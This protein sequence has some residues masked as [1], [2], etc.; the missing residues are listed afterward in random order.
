MKSA[1]EILKIKKE[2]QQ[3]KLIEN[4][5]RISEEMLALEKALNK[6]ESDDEDTKPYVEVDLIIKT[7]EVKTLLDQQGYYIDKTNQNIPVNTTRIYLD[8]ES[9]DIATRRYINV[10]SINGR[11]I[12]SLGGTIYNTDDDKNAMGNKTK[13]TAEDWIN[14][15]Q[16][17]SKLRTCQR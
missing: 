2:R 12:N 11:D 1:Q 17:L 14:A 15:L 3:Q 4:Q 13:I 16:Y 10:N 8:R 7:K 9:Y 5:N 6:Y